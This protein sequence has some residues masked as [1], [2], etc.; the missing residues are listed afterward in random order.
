M[1]S[2]CGQRFRKRLQES[3]CALSL[4]LAQAWLAWGLRQCFRRA[5]AL[6]LLCTSTVHKQFP[7]MPAADE[8]TTTLPGTVH[9]CI[10]RR[11]RRCHVANH[12]CILQVPT[13]L[14][15]LPEVLPA[16]RKSVQL[17]AQLQSQTSVEALDWLCAERDANAVLAKHLRTEHTDK[18]SNQSAS[19][20]LPAAQSAFP[21]HP[22]CQDGDRN[23]FV[24][25]GGAPSSMARSGA[26]AAAVQTAPRLTGSSSAACSRHVMLLAADCVWLADLV[27]PFLDAL[28]RLRKGLG[29]H[30]RLSLLLAYKSRSRQV[31]ELLFDGLREHFEVSE[32]PVL[33]CERRGSVGIWWCEPRKQSK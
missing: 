30:D 16:L 20:P 31:D 32:A 33:P 25:S 10:Y 3:I 5:S 27:Q 9:R 18:T 8:L 22:G 6:L 12:F 23:S 7:C 21:M 4:G 24:S 28:Q 11:I 19:A 1:A 17:N 29:P 14:T 26:L 2:I 15:D 13:V